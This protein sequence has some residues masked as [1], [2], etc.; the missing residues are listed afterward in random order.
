MWN[1]YSKGSKYEGFNLGF[2][3]QSLVDAIEQQLQ[4]YQC[5]V[6]L[7][8]IVYEREQQE[9]LIHDFIRK[10]IEHFEVGEEEILR[11]MASNQ[12]LKWS[13]VFKY[14]CFKHEEEVRLIIDVGIEKSKTQKKIPQIPVYYRITNGY[15]VPYIK[16]SIE[17]DCLSYET[18]GPLMCSDIHLQMCLTFGVHITYCVFCACSRIFCV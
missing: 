2:Y 5:N 10:T 7:Y 6:N 9:T 12:L 4:A 13:L 14:D 11:Y 18:I 3:S 8:P 1:Y 16:L 15:T 17:K